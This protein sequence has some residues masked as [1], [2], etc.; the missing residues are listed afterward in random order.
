MNCVLGDVVDCLR[1]LAIGA[2]NPLVLLPYFILTSI[3]V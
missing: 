1:D 2:E 3:A